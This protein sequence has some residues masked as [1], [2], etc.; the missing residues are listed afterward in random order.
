MILQLLGLIAIVV[1]AYFVFTTAKEYGRSAGLWALITVGIGVAF[2]WILPVVIAT[3]VTVVLVA[4]GTRPERV[5]DAIGWWGFAIMVLGLALSFVFMFLVLRHVA[6]LPDE[7]E[8]TDLRVP[9]PPTFDPS[10][11]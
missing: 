7:A 10:D 5:A 9:P 6:K 4:T 11:D 2:Q 1:C 3:V 8:E